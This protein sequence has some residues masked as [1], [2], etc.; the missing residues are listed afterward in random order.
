MHVVLLH[1]LRL[2]IEYSAHDKS[3]QTHLLFRYNKFRKVHWQILTPRFEN[4]SDKENE[5]GFPQ[6]RVHPFSQ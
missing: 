4:A 2:S 6:Q 5:Y 1:D 3:N